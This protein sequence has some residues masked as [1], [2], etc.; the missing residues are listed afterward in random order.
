MS[1]DMVERLAF[2]LSGLDQHGWRELP[3]NDRAD[4]YR[5]SGPKGVT[6]DGFRQQA[7]AAIEAMRE[8]TE[9]MVRRTLVQ[10]EPSESQ[11]DFAAGV[12]EGMPPLPPHRQRDGINA[13]AD[14]V[15]DWQAMIDAALN[16]KGVEG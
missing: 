11:F 1:E 8:P 13:A 9:E 14:I 12:I 3:E 16:Q 5:F 2:K 6:K 10:T 15:K 7:R 4:M